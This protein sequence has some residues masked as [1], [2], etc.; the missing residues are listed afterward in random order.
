LSDEAYR[1]IETLIDLYDR[2]V[3]QADRALGRLLEQLEREGLAA[4]TLVLVTS[5]HGEGL[6]QRSP[7]AGEERKTEVFF[8]ALYYSH[9]VQLYSEQVHVPLVL[10]G[11]GVPSGPV[12]SDVSLL[13]VVPT[14]LDLLAIEAPRDLSGLSLLDRAA[15]GARDEVFAV[16]SRVTT[17]TV[18]GRWRLH[19]PRE[20]RVQRFGATP[21]L[22]DLLADPL[23]V[24]PVDDP[25]R[26]ADLQTRIARW[27][28][29]YERVSVD[30]TDPAQAAILEALGY[31]GEADR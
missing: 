30:A 18:G 24:S 14:L 16:C 10:R 12:D 28:A 8:P 23:E 19:Q 26:V 9:G 20:F 13:D 31:T 11:P 17:V 21:A 29:D 22:F 5:D 4:D 15:L 3:S 7:A 27:R 6:W 1:G 25:Q 2:D